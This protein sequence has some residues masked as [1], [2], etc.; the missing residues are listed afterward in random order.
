M[1][2]MSYQL[3]DWQT[4]V[5]DGQELWKK[6]NTAV[7]FT[8]WEPKLNHPLYEFLDS[9]G[10][11]QIMTLRVN[12]EM[13]GYC[14][15]T[16]QLHSHYVDKICAMEDSLYI[17]RDRCPGM[18]LVIRYRQLVRNTLEA[19][20]ERSVVRVFFN[21]RIGATF[22]PRILEGFH[23]KPIDVVFTMELS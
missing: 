16:I 18:T 5:Q 15:M 4:F 19:L 7:G 23:L 21:T 9:N 20:R 11:L 8:D 2:G 6:Q 14:I 17:D 13:I 3:E 1:V 10:L 22:L 12:N